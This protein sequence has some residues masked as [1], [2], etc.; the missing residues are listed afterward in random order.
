MNPAVKLDKHEPR[1]SYR[2]I[3][4]CSQVDSQVVALNPGCLR[5]AFDSKASAKCQSFFGEQ[6]VRRCECEVRA[7]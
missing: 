1:N 4:A 5:W 7:K 6:R 3:L 2:W